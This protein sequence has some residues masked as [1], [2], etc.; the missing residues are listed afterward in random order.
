[1]RRAPYAFWIS[2]VAVLASG[3]AYAYLS[4]LGA[5]FSNAEFTSPSGTSI[6]FELPLD[7]YVPSGTGSVRAIMH[8]RHPLIGTYDVVVDD[9]LSRL[10]IN[11][12]PVLLRERVC[13][14]DPYPL[15]L[16]AHIEPGGNV[17]RATI[18]NTGGEIRFDMKPS[19]SDPALR[20]IMLAFLGSIF[21]GA[22]A[23]TLSSFPDRRSLKD[24]WHAVVAACQQLRIRT[25]DRK[26]PQRQREFRRRKKQERRPNRIG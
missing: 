24:E 20:S 17:I 4:A 19:P 11:G 7:R 10:D 23:F 26:E 9:C 5:R 8:V 22:Y 6:P 1:M 13:W 2:V 3:G 15:D 25:D 18:E 16:S 14:P 12:E 21:L